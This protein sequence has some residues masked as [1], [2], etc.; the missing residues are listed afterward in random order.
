M[1]A[2]KSLFLAHLVMVASTYKEVKKILLEMEPLIF[3]IDLSCVQLCSLKNIQPKNNH[4]ISTPQWKGLLAFSKQFNSSLI[5][6]L[7]R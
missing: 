3:P 1:P 4:Q 5:Y 7:E 6:W 2:E